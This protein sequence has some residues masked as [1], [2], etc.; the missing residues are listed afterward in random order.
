MKIRKMTVDAAAD[1]GRAKFLELYGNGKMDERVRAAGTLN[2]VIK[3][4]MCTVKAIFHVRGRGEFDPYVL[5]SAEVN[6]ITGAMTV[7]TAEDA[8]FLHDQEFQTGDEP[9]A[10]FRK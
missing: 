5:F 10:E 4:D 8:T 3:G 9:D 6:R 1:I 2:T 7:T